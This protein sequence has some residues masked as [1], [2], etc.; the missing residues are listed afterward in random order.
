MPVLDTNGQPIGAEELELAEELLAGSLDS[1]IN[2]LRVIAQRHR[3]KEEAEKFYQPLLEIYVKARKDL[4]SKCREVASGKQ[5]ITVTDFLSGYLD[6]VAAAAVKKVDQNSPAFR[7]FLFFVATG[8]GNPAYRALIGGAQG[9]IPEP[10]QDREESLQASIGDFRFSDEPAPG[11][12]KIETYHPGTDS[13]KALYTLR[14][15]NSTTLTEPVRKA[16]SDFANILK[17]FED[18]CHTKKKKGK[19]TVTPGTEKDMG[20]MVELFRK[21]VEACNKFVTDNRETR[22]DLV[23]QY[24]KT[25]GPFL[26]AFKDLDYQRAKEFFDAKYLNVPDA[27]PV[28]P[29]YEATTADDAKVSRSQYL[30]F[31]GVW[32]RQGVMGKRIYAALGARPDTAQTLR[33]KLQELYD[34]ARILARHQNK[35]N[36]EMDFSF[37]TLEADGMALLEQR[38]H[39]EQTLDAMEIFSRLGKNGSRL[40]QRKIEEVNKVRATLHQDS[41]TLAGRTQEASRIRLKKLRGELTDRRVINGIDLLDEELTGKRK[42][43]ASEVTDLARLPKVPRD[44][45]QPLDLEGEIE[46]IRGRLSEK[47]NGYELAN[48]C[49]PKLIALHLITAYRD[50]D[51]HAVIDGAEYERVTQ[52]VSRH[53]AVRHRC[54]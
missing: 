24:R 18:N 20:I 11:I 43:R 29:D 10:V 16:V 25:C 31:T 38:E 40:T 51:R 34:K 6:A 3:N 21:M 33:A 28:V 19:I 9:P 32:A 1:H 42:P 53:R 17:A 44:V 41:V 54:G 36:G 12:E 13:V 35:P 49:V 4:V 50:A 27:E 15:G 48:E 45:A 46:G 2:W 22:P 39:F 7:D 26:A 14:T 52:I 47:A 5:N 30:N 23:E 8:W 37:N